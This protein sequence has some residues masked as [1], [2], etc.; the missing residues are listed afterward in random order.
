MTGEMTIGEAELPLLAEG[1]IL[2]QGSSKRNEFDMA[3]FERLATK[4]ALP[5]ADGLG[6]SVVFLGWDRDP[7]GASTGI[8]Y[9]SSQPGTDGIGEA[10]SAV[11]SAP[12]AFDPARIY[13]ARARCPW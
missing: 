10:E 7:A 5:R 12:D 1:T 4:T 13:I 2:V 11:G 3:T 9:W 6:H 8:R